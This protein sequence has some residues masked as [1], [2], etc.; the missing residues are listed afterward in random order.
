MRL[1]ESVKNEGK[2]EIFQKKAVILRKER[3]QKVQQ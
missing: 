2:L 1:K 3:K